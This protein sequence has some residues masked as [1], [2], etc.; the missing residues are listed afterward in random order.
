MADRDKSVLQHIR[1]HCDDI[2]G[3]IERFGEDYDVFTSDKA[4]FNAVS[5]G[6]LQIGELAGSLSEEYRAKTCGTIP[7]SNIKG[8]RNIVAHDYGSVDEGLLWETATEDIPV[9][10]AFCNSELERMNKAK[11]G[12]AH[13]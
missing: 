12:A 8:M 5:M 9:L 6:I 3:F 7:W 4:Y 13:L 11:D 1:S 10:L 2:E